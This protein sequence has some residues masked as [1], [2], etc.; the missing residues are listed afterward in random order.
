MA[1]IEQ[2]GLEKE[3][4][5]QRKAGKSL[6]EISNWLKE[7]GVK[8]SREGLRKWFKDR[9][10]H[11]VVDN[12][13]TKVDKKDQKVEAVNLL[14]KFLI[15]ADELLEKGKIKITADSILK[16]INLVLNGDTGEGAKQFI[17]QIIQN[18]REDEKVNASLQ[19]SNKLLE[20]YQQV[21]SSAE[22]EAGGD[23]NN[24]SD[25]VGEPRNSES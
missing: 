3:V 18:M 15:K 13:L 16:A 17:L 24:N 9:D 10:V 11:V 8:I 25:G 6:G 4:I 12:G 21:Q 23:I 7:R 5:A 22:G 1:K 19:I 20:R 2:Y 14:N